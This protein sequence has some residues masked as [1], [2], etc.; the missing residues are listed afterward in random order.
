[1][2][3]LS[4]LTVIFFSVHATLAQQYVG[5]HMYPD[6]SWGFRGWWYYDSRPDIHALVQT[7]YS[8]MTHTT[9]PWAGGWGA[10]PEYPGVMAA[11]WWPNDHPDSL[12]GRGGI[13]IFHSSI[14]VSYPGTNI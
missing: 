10:Q 14:K 1:M 2:H 5:L 8:Q 13:V 12:G 4:V 7:A 11:S 3:I 9:L 6:N